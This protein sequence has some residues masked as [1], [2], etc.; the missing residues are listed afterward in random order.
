MYFKFLEKLR[1]FRNPS[2]KWAKDSIEFLKEYYD[3][4]IITNCGEDVRVS[5][6]K[7]LEKHFGKDTFKNIYTLP[8]HSSKKDIYN[9]YEHAI[10]IDDE[11]PNIIDA[12]NSLKNHKVFWMSY[13]PL[14]KKI[15]DNKY[16]NLLEKQYKKTSW[17]NVISYIKNN[18]LMK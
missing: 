11:L 2:N 12:E 8:F 17:N 3:I 15:A 10:V 14:F 1:F 7:N 13:Y 4:D 9:L 18:N 6:I 5:R 16:D